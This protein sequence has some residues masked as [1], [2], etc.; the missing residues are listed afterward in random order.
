MEDI[1]VDINQ[2]PTDKTKVLY[3]AV[4]KDYNIG[5]FDEFSKKLQDPSKR[6]AFYKGVGSE[7]NLGSYDEFS[8]KVGAVE[9]KN[10]GGTISP[11]ELQ[12]QLPEDK[13]L[14][15][16]VPKEQQVLTPDLSFKSVTEKFPSAPDQQHIKKEGEWKNIIQNVAA[17]IELTGTKLASGGA[18]IIRDLSSNIVKNPDLYDARGNKTKEAEDATWLSDPLGKVV[19]GLNGNQ[20]RMQEVVRNN[21]LPSTYWGNAVSAASEMT[22][23]LLA[24]GLMPEAKAAQAASAISK[25]GSLAFN[26][27]TKYLALKG[28]LEGYSE[29]KQKGGTAGEAIVEGG[30]QSIKGIGTGIEMAL[31]GAGSNVATKSIMKQAE[32]AGLTGVKGLV[33]KE[34]VNL[35]TDVAA[36]GLL[37][38][39][40]HAALEGRFATGKEIA[41]GT[42]IAALFRIKG[43]LENLK[44]RGKINKALNELQDFRQGV[45]ISNFVDATPESIK[46]VYNGKESA[47]EL[48]LKALQFAKAAK[49]TNVHNRTYT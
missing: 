46:E 30:K 6:E 22:P 2:N 40:S 13:N 14:L 17:N 16:K 31:L 9:K 12:S 44:E 36:F 10:L 3:D 11:T 1:N 19:L 43:G 4:S 47:D 39:Y 26:N 33:T 18:T 7:Y 34:L 25:I 28:G 41:D 21:S 32:M 8:K 15:T 49:E 24:T 38:P 48:N 27:F 23:D 5:T 35:G 29:E 45:A 37:S 20:E 42:G